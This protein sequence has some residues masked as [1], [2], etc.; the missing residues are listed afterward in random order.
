MCNMAIW[1]IFSKKKIGYFFKMVNYLAT[2]SFFKFKKLA[3]LYIFFITNVATQ[4]IWKVCILTISG[5][6]GL[7]TTFYAHYI[8]EQGSSH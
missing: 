5:L 8:I 3:I 6:K 7:H 4:N 2:F 1:A